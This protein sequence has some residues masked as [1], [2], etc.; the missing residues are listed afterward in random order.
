MNQYK[1]EIKVMT[2]SYFFNPIEIGGY[3][4]SNWDNENLTHKSDGWLITKNVFANDY[5]EAYK[6]FKI[7][8]NKILSRMSFISSCSIKYEV[9]STLIFRLNNN[10]ENYF[11]MIY[12]ENKD[13]GMSFDS[14]EV[15]ALGELL[16]ED[17]NPLFEFLSAS[18]RADHPNV[19]LALLILALESLA[20]EEYK[21]EKCVCGKKRSFAVTKKSFIK[22][23]ISND[24]V[25][26]YIFGYK[27]I[28]NKLFHGKTFYLDKDGDYINILR[29]AI[30]KHFNQIYSININDKIV[31]A[32]RIQNNSYYS[33]VVLGKSKK[34]T[35]IDSINLINLTYLYYNALNTD[36]VPRE[37]GKPEYYEFFDDVNKADF[38]NMSY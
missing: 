10:L 4:F 25:Y 22:T 15:S 14:E 19:Q 20:G 21:T 1:I 18:N 26:E 8:L 36:H 6:D 5:E 11:Y 29:N 30:I 32:P 13:V 33:C 38:E 12:L 2:S 3:K 16:N 28:R 31:G 27:G 37:D 17:N 9:C 34:D 35:K 7:N 24:D 23:L